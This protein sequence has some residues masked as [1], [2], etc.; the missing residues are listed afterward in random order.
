MHML[1]PQVEQTPASCAASRTPRLLLETCVKKQTEK[2]VEHWKRCENI[3][4]NHNYVGH[5][6]R[7][8]WWPGSVGF[9]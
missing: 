5:Y 3:V 4:F 1:L 6:E 8:D 7:S 2:G 9:Q